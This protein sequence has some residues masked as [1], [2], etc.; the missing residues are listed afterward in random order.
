MQLKNPHIAAP[1]QRIAPLRIPARR[2]M[3]MPMQVSIAAC[4]DITSGA[5]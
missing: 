2:A 4:H 3:A 1:P 5:R